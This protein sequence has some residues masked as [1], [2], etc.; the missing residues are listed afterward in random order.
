M[1]KSE[2]SSLQKFAVLLGSTFTA[3][4]YIILRVNR[5]EINI[6]DKFW[7]SL[8]LITSMF[9]TNRCIIGRIIKL[10]TKKNN[11]G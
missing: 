4:F 5:V 2:E 10:I 6:I 7:C 1:L 8:P 11:Y 3:C 9:V